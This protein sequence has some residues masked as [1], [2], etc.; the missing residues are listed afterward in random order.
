VHD[1]E[2]LKRLEQVL[3]SRILALHARVEAT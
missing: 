2:R 3:Y 1:R